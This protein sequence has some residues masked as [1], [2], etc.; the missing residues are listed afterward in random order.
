MHGQQN[1]RYAKMHGQQ[2]IKTQNYFEVLLERRV[3]KAGRILY[4]S[5]CEY[6][7]N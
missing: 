1:D 6:F 3:K 2:N 7:Y 5:K 4:F